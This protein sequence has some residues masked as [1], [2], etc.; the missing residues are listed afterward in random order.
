MRRVFLFA[1]VFLLLAGLIG[2]LSYVQFTFKPQM[3][4]TIIGKMAPPPASVAVTEAKTET[5]SPRIPA[6][7]S[8]RAVKGVDLAPQVGGSITAI[9]VESGQ[10]VKAGAPLFNIDTT[11]EE[12]DLQNNLATL[13]NAE[14]VLERQRQLTLTGNTTK[15]NVDAAQAARDQAA[16]SVA[17]VRALIAQKKIVAPFAGRLGIRR[18][19]L[20]Q[21][22]APGTNLITLQALNP[23]FVDF[24]L[25]EQA[26]ADLKTGETVE[27]NVDTFPGRVFSGK[28]QTIDSKVDQATRNVLVRAIFDNDDLAL[29]PGMFANVAVIA[30]APKAVVTLPR[31]AV[32][33]SLYGD[34]I[35]V[36]VPDEQPSSGAAQAAPLAGDVPYKVERRFVKTGEE[37]GDR[38]VITSGVKAGELVVSEGQLKLQSG[39]RVKIDRNA[40][41]KAPAVLPKE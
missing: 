16:A 41:L 14:L 21:Y 9:L 33:Y 11:V 31:T 1:V 10:D 22:V 37:R 29:R 24:P 35:F 5:W 17:R 13:K 36:V 7:G 8:F 19:D 30:G 34:A 27:V 12:A 25:P 3:L 15:A 26:L 18:V 2:G 39:A 23:I 6:I 20:G 32:T 28:V 38:V 40:G 4:K